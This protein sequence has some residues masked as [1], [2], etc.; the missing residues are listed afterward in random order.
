MVKRASEARRSRHRIFIRAAIEEG[1]QNVL[2]CGVLSIA[3]ATGQYT[4]LLLPVATITVGKV[5]VRVTVRQPNI[6]DVDSSIQ[7]ENIEVREMVST[8][9]SDVC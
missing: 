2:T 8:D 4:R 1:K 9:S 7:R 6:K 3:G 5:K